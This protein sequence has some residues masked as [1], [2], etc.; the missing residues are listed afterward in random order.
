MRLTTL[1]L[2]AIPWKKA[3][4]FV[5]VI[6]FCALAFY[7]E[8]FLVGISEKAYFK[9]LKKKSKTKLS[10]RALV[11]IVGGILI[12]VSLLITYFFYLNK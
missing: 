3:G 11:T 5:I 9:R 6:I 4:A 7:K 1:Y 12:V 10:G 2:E 8:D